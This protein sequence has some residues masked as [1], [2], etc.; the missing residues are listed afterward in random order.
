[1]EIL[2]M[3]IGWIIGLLREGYKLMKKARDIVRAINFINNKI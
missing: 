2:N 1:M 3:L